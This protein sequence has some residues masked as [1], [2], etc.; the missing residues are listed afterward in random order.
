VAK[1]DPYFG[2]GA[3][4]YKYEL[5]TIVDLPTGTADARIKVEKYVTECLRFTDNAAVLKRRDTNI[6]MASWFPQ[7]T[8][9]RWRVEL[10]ASIEPQ[11]E[12]WDESFAGFDL[13]D[14]NTSP[15]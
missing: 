10:E 3:M 2:V 4:R 6:L 11:P 8:M 7:R 1:M 5:P 15:W 12:S 14:Y 9:R 13:S